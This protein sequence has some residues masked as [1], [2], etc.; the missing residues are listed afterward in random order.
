MITD[1]NAVPLSRRS[2]LVGGGVLLG[3]LSGRPAS[4]RSGGDHPLARHARQELRRRSLGSPPPQYLYRLERELATL[5]RNRCWPVWQAA[6]NT[7]AEA[8]RDRVVIVA[9]EAAMLSSL[10]AHLLGITTVDPVQWRVPTDYFVHQPCSDFADL[11]VSESARLDFIGR[12]RPTRVEVRAA[13]GDTPERLYLHF[14]RGADGPVVLRLFRDHRLN[15]LQTAISAGFNRSAVDLAAVSELVK[16]SRAFAPPFDRE[17][18]AW[19]A[20]G[21][22]DFEEVAAALALMRV[23]DNGWEAQPVLD[24]LWRVFFARGNDVPDA[25]APFVEATGELLL[26]NEQIGRITKSLAGFSFEEA[27]RFRW[28]AS[29]QRR[30]RMPEWRERFLQRARSTY[31][32]APTRPTRS[33]TS[34]GAIHS[35]TVAVGSLSPRRRSGSG[36]PTRSGGSTPMAVAELERSDDVHRSHRRAALRA[37]SSGRSRVAQS[38]ISGRRGAAGR[39]GES[40]DE[41]GRAGA[42]RQRGERA[43]V[44]DHRDG[45]AHVAWPLRLRRR[46]SHTA[47]GRWPALGHCHRVQPRDRSPCHSAR[48]RGGRH[49]DGPAALLRQRPHRLGRLHR[50]R[51]R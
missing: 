36:P 22:A 28:A 19:V 50:L 44:G 23:E 25:C 9:D 43:E 35:C 39:V 38:R 30:D 12:L 4:A 45:R 49:P 18:A 31:G 40:P 17:D 41:C 7:A 24:D 14:G 27:Q 16:R 33:A 11:A 20:R 13:R 5:Q 47:S 32:L 2:L 46:S 15:T 3:A 10:V 37:G 29:S 21:F 26:Y 42:R 48:G 6:F 34:C 1:D 51:C 8:G